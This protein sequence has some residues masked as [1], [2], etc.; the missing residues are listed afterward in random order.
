MAKEP[1]SS[2]GRSEGR[3]AQSAPNW[4]EIR[5]A[6][7]PSLDEL[8]DFDRMLLG[9]THLPRFDRTSIYAARVRNTS[10]VGSQPETSQLHASGLV[11]FEL[12]I[13][14]AS[15]QRSAL[16]HYACELPLGHE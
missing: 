14:P 9:T 8:A 7:A 3:A 11:H 12:F 5:A 6:W 2:A 10:R 1:A 4:F 16:P 13:R 15:P